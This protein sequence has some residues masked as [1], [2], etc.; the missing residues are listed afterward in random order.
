MVRLVP[1]FNAIRLKEMTTGLNNE[2]CAVVGFFFLLREWYR[3]VAKEK[4][5]KICN[6][7]GVKKIYCISVSI[8][9]LF[10]KLLH[11][12]DVHHT[13]SSKVRT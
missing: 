6:Q 4:H 11:P 9:E 5:V 10:I 2:A 12:I 13:L 1:L 3:S 8:I 7:H